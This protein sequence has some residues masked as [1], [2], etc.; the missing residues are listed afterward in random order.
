M[1]FNLSEIRDYIRVEADIQGLK[2]YT[3][4]IDAMINQELRQFTGKSKYQEMYDTTTFTVADPTVNTFSLPV[5][6]QMFDTLTYVQPSDTNTTPLNL[7]QGKGLNICANGKPM[8]YRRQGNVFFVYPYLNLCLNDQLVLGYYKFATLQNETDLFPVESLEKA[9]I[10]KV[11]ARMLAKVSSQRAQMAQME[12]K[13]A[14]Q[15]SRVENA[16]NS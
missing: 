3:V 16:G 8:Y 7:T 13:E 12:A 4:L 9:V 1:A 2:E 10:Q 14:Y 15:D 11:I 5:D 6:F